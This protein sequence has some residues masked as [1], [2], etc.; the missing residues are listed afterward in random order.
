VAIKVKA[1][2]EI[3]KDAPVT[4]A[5]PNPLKIPVIT[6]ASSRTPNIIIRAA[7]IMFMDI[8]ML[9]KS[10]QTKQELE[11]YSQFADLVYRRK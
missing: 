6:G 5:S 4:S 2:I 10:K 8:R 11:T 9:L 3:P 1:K 7:K